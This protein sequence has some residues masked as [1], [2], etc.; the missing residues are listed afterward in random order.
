MPRSTQK[1]IVLLSIGVYAAAI[2]FFKV[3]FATFHQLKWM[4][5]EKCCRKLKYETVRIEHLRAFWRDSYR[6]YN[7]AI[8]DKKAREMAD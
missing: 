4:I 3:L 5:F 6:E 7:R 2:M 8:R 1:G